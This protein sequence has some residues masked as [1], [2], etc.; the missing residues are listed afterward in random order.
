MNPYGRGLPTQPVQQT[1]HS[2][3]TSFGG[4][5]FTPASSAPVMQPLA[6]QPLF[7]P[8]GVFTPTHV[9]VASTQ[10]PPTKP[11]P[12]PYNTDTATSWNDPPVLKSKVGVAL[13]SKN[14]IVACTVQSVMVSYYTYTLLPCVRTQSHHPVAGGGIAPITAPIMAPVMAPISV[15]VQPQ[16]EQAPPTPQDHHTPLQSPAQKVT[17]NA[18]L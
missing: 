10:A 18:V 16:H 7:Q 12:D 17:T 2:G 5:M 3:S 14:L 8:P 13:H 6:P 9:G 4:Q 15:P 11:E 1:S